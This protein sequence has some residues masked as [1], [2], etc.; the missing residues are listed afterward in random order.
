[1]LKVRGQNA[2]GTVTKRSRDGGKSLKGR[3]KRLKGRLQL[4]TG[5]VSPDPHFAGIPDMFLPRVPPHTP[6]TVDRQKHIGPAK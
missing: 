3:R 5:A 6:V 4:A 2:E 1:M